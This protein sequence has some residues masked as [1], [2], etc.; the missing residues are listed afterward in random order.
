M[1]RLLAVGCVPAP[2]LHPST[3]S[4]SCSR[5][6]RWA[7]VRWAV[8]RHLTAQHQ[9]PPL[10]E[11]APSRPHA[12]R[13]LPCPA[14]L[15]MT[16][17]CSWPSGAACP[18]ARYCSPAPSS[19][20]GPSR[21]PP[22]SACSAQPMPASRPPGNPQVCAVGWRGPHR[23]GCVHPGC[24]HL[25]VCAWLCAPAACAT[26]V[27]RPAH[28]GVCRGGPGAACGL[29]QAPHGAHERAQLQPLWRQSH[30]GC[31]PRPLARPAS[32]LQPLWELGSL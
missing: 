11:A 15:Q 2:A 29:L 26:H 23:G 17:C 9:C 32:Q 27:A 1:E 21:C 12:P 28:P 7:V 10:Q 18:P 22:P 24:V 20:S 8:V 25:A 6:R 30:G 5:R 3:A 14:L 4:R 31:A 19:S 13:R 16:R